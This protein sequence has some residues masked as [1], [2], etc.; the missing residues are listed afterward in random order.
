MHCMTIP[1]MVL[2]FHRVMHFSMTACADCSQLHTAQAERG[3]GRTLAS[4]VIECK[5]NPGHEASS[6]IAA[7]AVEG[8]VAQRS[9]ILC[10]RHA[11]C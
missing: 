7:M 6:G 10:A 5:E 4:A 9:P 11:I 1:D 2:D 3:G 8:N